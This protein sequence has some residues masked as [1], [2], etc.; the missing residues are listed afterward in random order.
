MKILEA[1]ISGPERYG[2]SGYERYLFY[3]LATETGLRRGELLTL[4][5]VSFDLKNRTV[6]VKG[7]EHTK[8][9]EDVIR[10]VSESTAAMLKEFIANKLPTVKLFN[11][12]PVKASAEMIKEDCEAAGVDIYNRR[13]Q[14]RVFHSLR[15]CCG[16]FLAAK[17]VHPKV[18]QE[19]MRHK[20]INLT[21]SRYTHTLRDQEAKAVNSLPDFTIRRATGTE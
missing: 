13:G 5:P 17:G 19:I 16:S 3:I 8:H 11:L 20:D 2:L 4:T 21:M 14:K 7:E 15:H 9:P 10:K 6:F 18:I 1:A 12:H